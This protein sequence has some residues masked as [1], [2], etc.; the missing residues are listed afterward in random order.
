MAF[1]DKKKVWKV[2]MG[3]VFLTLSM[4]LN[5]NCFYSIFAKKYNSHGHKN[6]KLYLGIN[7]SVLLLCVHP[8][9][10]LLLNS[11]KPS[12]VILRLKK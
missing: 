1:K 4:I 3:Q 10:V 9:K 7:V 12:T 5:L 6:I 8:K 2:L 11:N